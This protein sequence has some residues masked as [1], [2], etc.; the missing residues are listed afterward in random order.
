MRMRVSAY[1]RRV[2]PASSV[3]RDRRHRWP[4]ALRNARL[5]GCSTRLEPSISKQQG[6]AQ[7]TAAREGAGATVAAPEQ[8]VALQP[9]QHSIWKI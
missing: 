3:K 8:L 5:P 4:S 7:G 1:N 9:V 6:L 2:H